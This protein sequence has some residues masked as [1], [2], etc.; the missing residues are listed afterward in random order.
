MSGDGDRSRGEGLHFGSAREACWDD[1]WIQAHQK[2]GRGL[3]YTVNEKGMR[4]KTCHY[5]FFLDTV[6]LEEFSDIRQDPNMNSYI[7]HRTLA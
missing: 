1:E 7:P 3:R 6:L 2:L 4:S 5:S